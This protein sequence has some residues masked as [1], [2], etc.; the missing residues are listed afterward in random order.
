M[1]ALYGQIADEAN[2]FVKHATQEVRMAFVRKVYS[3]LCVQ[4]LVTVAI[5]GYIM[6]MP[7][8]WLVDNMW[9]MQVSLVGTLITTCVIACCP[10]LCRSYPSNYFV[11][12]G[13][14]ACEA[15]LVGVV[16]AQYT[17]GLVGLC[18]AVTA[19]IFLC[20]TAYAWTTKNDFTGFGPYLYAGLIALFCLGC[21]FPL[22]Q[23]LGV[24]VA[25]VKL[26][27]AAGGVLLFTMFIVYDTQL[28]IGTGHKLEFGVDDYVFAA[29][30]I[31]LD[32]IN[33]FLDLL[34]MLSS[35]D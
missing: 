12:F 24:N 2:P 8:Q 15:V 22:L 13:F 35:D 9:L 6:R 33:I 23:L 18:A 27:Y 4:L 14:T 7:G 26:L 5:A 30:N 29:L 19:A 21:S 25:P 31:Y 16:S 34:Q 10:D 3:L 28:I 32:I 1:A 17:A 11:L 20:M